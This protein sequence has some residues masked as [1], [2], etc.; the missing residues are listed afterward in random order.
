MI[1]ATT[2]YMGRPGVSGAAVQD[3]VAVTPITPAVIL[4]SELKGSRFAGESVSDNLARRVVR[5]LLDRANR[6]SQWPI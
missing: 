2:R 5:S 1:H 4:H 3:H 6:S